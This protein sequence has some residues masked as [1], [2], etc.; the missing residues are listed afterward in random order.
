MRS[1]TIS[2]VPSPRPSATRASRKSATCPATRSANARQASPPSPAI[3]ACPISDIERP[4]SLEGPPERHLVGIL[5]F[6]AH[7][8][9]AGGPCHPKAKRLDH[10]GQVRGG[11]LA[12]KVRI[13]RQDHLGD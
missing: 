7:R 9:A 10:P 3:P 4:P 1:G 12:F 5:E 6:A 8:Q 2:S 13:G 11:R